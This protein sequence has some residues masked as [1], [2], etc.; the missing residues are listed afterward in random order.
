[1]SALVN[2][3]LALLTALDIDTITAAGGKPVEAVALL[4]LVAGQDVEPAK[5]WTAPTGGV[6]VACVNAS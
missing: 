1:M 6:E 2:D 3:A 5:G 4:A